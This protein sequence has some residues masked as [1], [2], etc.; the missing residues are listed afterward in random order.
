MKV[1]TADLTTLRAAVE[2]LDTAERRA[3]YATG[4]FPRSELVKD[5]DRRYRWDL[6]WLAVR[7]GA[8]LP[9]STHGYN[10]AHIDTALR[11]IVAPIA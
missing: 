3:Q 10:D 8:S 2:P 7:Q 11:T 4:R 1:S 5:L 9:D 6:Y